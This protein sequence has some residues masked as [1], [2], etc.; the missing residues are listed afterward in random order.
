MNAGERVAL[1]AVKGTIEGH[2]LLAKGSVRAAHQCKVKATSD[3]ARAYHQG[4]L[5]KS[6]DYLRSVRAIQR[7]VNA[8]EKEA[9]SG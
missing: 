1:A 4:S 6:V 2:L 9:E 8:L 7:S 3:Y 5:V